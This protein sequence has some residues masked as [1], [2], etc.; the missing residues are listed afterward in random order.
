M[1]NKNLIIGAVIILA[2]IFIG[3]FVFKD[4]RSSSDIN[5]QKGNSSKT[6]FEWSQ[7]GTW[8]NTELKDVRTGKIFTIN[9]FRE[10][11]ILLETFAVWCPTCLKQ[12]RKIGELHKEIGNEFVSI[13]LDT[14]QSED[15]NKVREHIENNAL[16]WYFAVSPISL[17]EDLINNF[18]PGI[19]SAPSAPVI[20][21]CEDGRAR[22]LDTGVKDVDE[23]K[24]AI[25]SC[26]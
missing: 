26:Q 21:I 16:D 3:V 19:V 22:K 10:K 6:N 24:E 13:S 15:E 18:G 2:L 11:P 9:E 12:Q 14:D 7:V 5:I 23:L 17:T 20:L 1:V 25:T 4:N 8:G